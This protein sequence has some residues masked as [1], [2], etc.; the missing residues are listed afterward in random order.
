MDWR[1]WP[2][3]NSG[4]KRSSLSS[5]PFCTLPSTSTNWPSYS[6]SWKAYKLISLR[7]GV[8]EYLTQAKPCIQKSIQ[9]AELIFIIENQNKLKIYLNLIF[10]TPLYPKQ[11]FGLACI[12]SMLIFFFFVHPSGMVYLLQ[13]RTWYTPSCSKVLQLFACRPVSSH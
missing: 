3:E 4:P 2:W 1:F 12:H 7:R 9:L 6:L 8:F 13:L 11:T 10:P 5:Q